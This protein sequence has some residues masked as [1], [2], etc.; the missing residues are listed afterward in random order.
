ME[1]NDEIKSFIIDAINYSPYYRCIGMEV[2]EVSKERSKLV[3][4]NIPPR[5]NLY[6]SLHGGAATSLID[7]A[8]AI[9]LIPHLDENELEMVCIDLNTSFI[10]SVSEG[11]IFAEGRLTERKKRLA[12]MRAKVY[13]DEK[14]IAR[15]DTTYFIKSRE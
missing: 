12:F 8:S 11:P 15:G 6:G 14:L 4:K 9:A 2:E 7:S 3:I 10:T 5:L 13:N 1:L